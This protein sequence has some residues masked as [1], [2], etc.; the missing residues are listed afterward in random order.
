M[1]NL[2]NIV[3]KGIVT[4]CQSTEAYKHHRIDLGESDISQLTLVGCKTGSGAVPGVLKFGGDGDYKAWLVFDK[5]EV[6]AH[7]ELIEEYEF[8]ATFCSMSGE[9]SQ[10]RLDTWL[11]IYDDNA[12][13]C[14]LMGKR[15][16]VYRAGE[17]GCLIYVEVKK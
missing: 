8:L 9:R 2:K 10:S 11:K 13:A 14:H 7:Y 15:I 4:E 1:E 6:P 5:S 16:E 17:Y 3:K 12:L